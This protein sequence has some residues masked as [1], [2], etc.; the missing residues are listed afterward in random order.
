MF[1]LISVHLG[2]LELPYVLQSVSLEFV[3]VDLVLG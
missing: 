3:F 1:Q 2:A